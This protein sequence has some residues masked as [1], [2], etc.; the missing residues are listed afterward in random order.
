M[1]PVKMAKK[2]AGWAI[3]AQQ[4]AQAMNK[5]LATD[6]LGRNSAFER[7]LTNLKPPKVVLE[8]MN[9]G[10]YLDG[11]LVV[12]RNKQNIFSLSKDDPQSMTC[13]CCGTSHRFSRLDRVL[14]H[15]MSKKHHAKCK[16]QL[17]SADQERSQ[18]LLN[19]HCKADASNG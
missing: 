9:M 15:L 6:V 17:E 11:T 12:W 19:E 18:N 13:F 8:K 2:L 16:E 1:D 10:D 5:V 3:I 4:Y 7:M 14:T